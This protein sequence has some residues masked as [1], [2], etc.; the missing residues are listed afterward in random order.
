MGLHDVA[1]VDGSVAISELP[2]TTT[3]T[4][5]GQRRAKYLLAA[6]ATKT[7]I[8]EAGTSSG[9]LR[10]AEAAHAMNHPVGVV[11]GLTGNPA[12]TGCID[13]LER[14]SVTLVSSITDAD[15]LR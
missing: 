2:P 12:A 3:L 6:I 4:V 10:T 11:L 8:V 1:V 13:L 7:I 15:R 5:R 9:A 14:Y